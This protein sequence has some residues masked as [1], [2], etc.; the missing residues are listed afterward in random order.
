MQ[1]API[2]RDGHDAASGLRS[3]GRARRLRWTTDSAGLASCRRAGFAV[4]AHVGGTALTAEARNVDIWR[5]G[6]F[7]RGRSRGAL[8]VFFKAVALVLMGGAL[9][10]PCHIL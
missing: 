9:M 1:P 10:G 8:A 3:R 5:V 2:C 6:W 7:L 4:D